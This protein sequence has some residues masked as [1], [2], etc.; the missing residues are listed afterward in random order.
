MKLST[1]ANE[2]D[3]QRDI[4]PVKES[5]PKSQE[6]KAA[7]KNLPQGAE[8]TKLTVASSSRSLG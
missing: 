5:Q 1:R 6:V 7:P 3:K 2:P 8:E 4:S